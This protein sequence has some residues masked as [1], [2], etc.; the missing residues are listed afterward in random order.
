MCLL[1]AV[2]SVSSGCYAVWDQFDNGCMSV[3]NY[4]GSHLAWWQYKDSCCDCDCPHHFGK[5][6]RKGYRDIY[7]GKS[8]CTPVLPPR[9]YWSVWDQTAGGNS[10]IA[11]WREGYANGVIAAQQDGVGLQSQMPLY[12]PEG[13][14]PPNAQHEI[15]EQELIPEPTPLPA[16]PTPVPAEQTALP[17]DP[18]KTNRPDPISTRPGPAFLPTSRPIYREPSPAPSFNGVIR[19]RRND[20]PFRPADPPEANPF[21]RETPPNNEE[22]G[23]VTEP[24]MPRIVPSGYQPGPFTPDVRG[25]SGDRPN[26]FKPEVMGPSGFRP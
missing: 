9:S 20:N 2:T 26:A 14:I 6:F 17:Y 3:R 5:G 10:R 22:S 16:E 15:Y 24:G 19:P 12:Q 7:A 11:A 18:M 23:G 25:P 21:L 4:A 1:A 13:Y 8:G